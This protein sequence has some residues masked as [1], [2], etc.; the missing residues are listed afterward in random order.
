MI[1]LVLVFVAILFLQ[2]VVAECGENQI[3]INT[4]SLSELDKLQAIGPARGQAIIDSRPYGC[5]D[6]LIK[7]YGIGEKTV[8]SIKSQGLACV[9]DEDC[10]EA[11]DEADEEKEQ[12]LDTQSDEDE[13]SE[14]NKKEKRDVIKTTGYFESQ[15][16]SLSPQ[17][18]KREDD[19]QNSAGESYAMYGIVLFCVLLG[20]LWVIKLRKEKYQKNEF[21][22]GGHKED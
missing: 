7:I 15:P 4:A 13:S 17:T 3:D 22:D 19:S 21:R 20:V 14:E 10:S 5:L 9:V 16:I 8:G 12:N 11:E 18:I 6:E 2:F 1:K